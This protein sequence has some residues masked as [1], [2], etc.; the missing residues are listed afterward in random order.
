[1]VPLLVER[2]ELVKSNDFTDNLFKM[3]GLQALPI[4]G[5]PELDSLI[6]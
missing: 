3:K 1:M 5:I 2:Y 6:P 4:A